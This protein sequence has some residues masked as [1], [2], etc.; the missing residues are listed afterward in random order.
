MTS[1]RMYYIPDGRY[2]FI[3]RQRLEAIY[4]LRERWPTTLCSPSQYAYQ[5]QVAVRCAD[6][7]TGASLTTLSWLTPIVM[8]DHTDNADDDDMGRYVDHLGADS[9]DLALQP[10][11]IALSDV[12]GASDPD[13]AE[14]FEPD[15]EAE[16]ASRVL[17]HWEMPHVQ[18]SNFF[19]YFALTKPTQPMNSVDYNVD[20][21][22]DVDV[23]TITST[24][25]RPS[26]D[27]FPQQTFSPSDA[28]IL[29]S[30]NARLNDTCINGCAALMY[31][32]FLPSS[33]PCAI[34]STHDLPRIRFHADD[35]LLW[36]NISWTRFWEKPIW[37][38]PIHRPLPVGHWVLCTI[39]LRSRQLFLFDS[40]AE[41][42]PWKKDIKVSQLL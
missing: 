37:I 38:L 16:A 35:D 30:P 25:I 10:Q 28:S 3:L 41:Q 6:T 2:H 8:D 17:L 11:E 33:S 27:G 24:I 15:L 26:I 13:D 21:A 22:M 18:W 34:L 14:V 20:I 5:A 4:E 1:F 40:L 39:N 29:A 42:K 7:I 32:A 19:Y 9:S 12:L 23:P 31:S 36:R